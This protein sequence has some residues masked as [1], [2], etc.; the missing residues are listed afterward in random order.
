MTYLK[1]LLKHNKKNMPKSLYSELDDK[2]NE[3]RQAAVFSETEIL[4]ASEY[5]YS[6]VT[7]SSSPIPSI[8]KIE[9][10]S[11][12]EIILKAENITKEEFEEVWSKSSPLNE[13][14]E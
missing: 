13:D 4:Q 11:S 8:E 12:N 1:I 2:R 3:I 6:R 10:L 14:M 9:E 5:D 7:L